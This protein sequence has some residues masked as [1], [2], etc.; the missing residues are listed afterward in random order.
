MVELSASV[1]PQGP[2]GWGFTCSCS[3]NDHDH[4]FCASQD[5]LRN[6]SFLHVHVC[7]AP[8][9]AIRG[10][11]CVVYNCVRIADQSLLLYKKKIWAQKLHV[12]IKY[13]SFLHFLQL[14]ELL[15][16]LLLAYM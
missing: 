9:T 5:D 15:L 4:K 6:C 2:S 11:F 7:A 13:L 1:N 10:Y 3:L 14:S 8:I 12:Y 16:L